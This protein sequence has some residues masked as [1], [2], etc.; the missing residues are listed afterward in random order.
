MNL[1]RGALIEYG[2]DLIG[3]IPNVVIFQ[4]NP[5]SLSRVL[6]IP[7][8]PSGATQR[9]TTQAGEHTFEKISFKAH[10][11]AANLLA[12]DKVLARTFGIG[13]QLSALEKMVLPSSK[14]AGLVGA[15]IDAIGSAIAGGGAAPAAQPIP[16]EKYPRILFIWGLTRVLPVTI[17]SMTIG[18]LEYDAVLNPLRAEVDIS[19]SVIAVDE[20]SDDVLAKGALAFTTI[21]KEAQAVANLANTV[22]QVADLIPL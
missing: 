8:R 15:A 14:L 2:T 12:D 10:F 17:D 1:L 6:Q 7:P 4:Y 11:S 22:D 9:E 3:P 20:C 18:E 16:R 19:L 21:A 5:E 13:P